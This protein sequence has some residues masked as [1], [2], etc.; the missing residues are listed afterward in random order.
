MKLKLKAGVLNPP[1]DKHNKPCPNAVVKDVSTI[2]DYDRETLY[3]S[4]AGY[5]NLEE[6]EEENAVK[7]FEGTY[8]WTKEAKPA[9]YRTITP[10]EKD[11]EGN[12]TQAE[13]KK[14]ITPKFGA[15]SSITNVTATCNGGTDFGQVGALWIMAHEEWEDWEIVE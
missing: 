15:F 10:E 6:S 3:V 5:R 13:V 12:I 14:L 7:I 9:V 1:L 4:Y 11:S 2:F 8:T